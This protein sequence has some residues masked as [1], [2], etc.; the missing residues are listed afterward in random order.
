M[1]ELLRRP[2]PGTDRAPGAL[3]PPARPGHR[4]HRRRHGVQNP[5]P[6]LQRTSGRLRQDSRRQALRT[7]SGLPHRRLCRLQQIQPRPARRLR[8]GARPHREGRQEHG[9]HNRN[10]LRQDHP[11][12]HRLHTQGKGQGQDQD[13]EDRGHDHRQ[14]EHHHPSAQRRVAG[15]DHRRP[16]RLHRLRGQHRSQR[17]RHRREQAP[18]PECP[19]HSRIRHL[20]HP[21]PAGETAPHQARKAGRRLALEQPGA[22]LLRRRSVSS[23]GR[24]VLP[25]LGGAEKR[26]P[27]KDA[28]IPR[29]GA[30][31]HHNGGYRPSGGEARAQDFPFRRQGRG[32][33]DRRAGRA[34][35]RRQGEHRGHHRLHHRMVQ[36]PKEK[37]WQE[38]PTPDRTHRLRD[39]RSHQGHQQQ[40]QAFRQPR[41]G[42]RGHRP[43][44]RRQRH[45]H[46][47]LLRPVGD[48]RHRQGRQIP[49]HEGGGQGLL[50][51]GPALRGPVQPGRRPHHLQCD[52]PRGQDQ[53]LLRQALRHHLGH[54]RQ[55]I[56]HHHRRARV[57]DNV[58]LRQP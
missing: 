21:R 22:H 3:P 11:H 55:G 19:R 23:P 5:P 6:Q 28:G 53:R 10:P 26:H 34:D 58:V 38:L 42:F 41:G 9:G 33:Q 17:L 52:I 15:Q 7:L 13:Q 51:Q 35:G 50:R 27:C 29:A 30:Q 4:G 36:E 12:A 37:V 39:H 46:L 49:H 20:P 25:G 2:Q 8:Q 24:Q 18:V 47:R 1:D 56:R 32:R 16:L 57:P 54:P 44:A 43:Q 48:H 40:R 14:G 45:L 31:G